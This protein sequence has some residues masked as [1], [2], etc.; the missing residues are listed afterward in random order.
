[1][2]VI[3]AEALQMMLDAARREIAQL[4][5]ENAMLR[6][7]MMAEAEEMAMA[8]LMEMPEQAGIEAGRVWGYSLELH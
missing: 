7:D 4:R 6:A 1:M 8:E 2:P 3:T 5:T